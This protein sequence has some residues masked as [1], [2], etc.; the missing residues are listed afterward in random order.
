[1]VISVGVCAVICSSVQHLCYS[2]GQSARESCVVAF[3]D[4]SLGMISVTH[5]RSLTVAVGN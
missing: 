1:M 5:I 2:L 3:K 4:D